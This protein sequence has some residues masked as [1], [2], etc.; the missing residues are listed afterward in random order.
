[1]KKLFIISN[2]SI[3]NYEG[4][5]FCDNIDMKSTPE[6]LGKNF[7]VSIIAR[8]SRKIRSHK[9]NLKNVKTYGNIILYLIG[10]FS[11]LKENNHKY[12][13]I[14][15]SPFT[16]FACVFL[17]IF[18][19]K[20]IV[21]LRSDGYEEYR[22]KFGTI[23]KTIYHLMYTIVSKISHL[24]SCGE[25]ILKGKNGKLVFP[26]QLTSPWFSNH[27]EYKI[28]KIRLLYV[29]R[30]RVEKGI[31]SLLEIIKDNEEV[32][33]SIIGAE[34]MTINKIN[35]SNVNI[36]EIE[37]NE[38]NLI[39]F[40]DDHTIFVLPSFTEGRPMVLLESLSRLRPVIIFKEIEHVVGN[41]K[42][43]FVSER[44]AKSL[45]KLIAYIK[46]NYKDIQTTMKE[47][48]LPTNDD[49]IKEFEKLISDSV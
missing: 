14:S 16:F 40:Y 39:K 15:I 23:G 35:Q 44:N 26:S 25:H 31:Y 18:K 24:V 47:N 1:M 34:K 11:S 49:F 46:N 5:F 2:E 22:K 29:G 3:F 30:V 7:D 10:I 17:R 42:G 27:K 21:Y 9:I 33:L 12:L 19:K 28:D 43:I 48:R 6:G 13:I 20:S 4:N 41:K 45:F 36:Y 32:T 8:K 38:Q 37:T